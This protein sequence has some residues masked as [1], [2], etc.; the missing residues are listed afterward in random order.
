MTD[1]QLMNAGAS[2]ARR[3]KTLNDNPWKINCRQF[4]MWQ[5]GWLRGKREHLV[6]QSSRTEVPN[7]VKETPTPSNNRN[8][9]RVRV[10]SVPVRFCLARKK[11]S[12]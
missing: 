5:E 10:L 4:D 8:E 6:E 3:G 12:S 1:E 7:P 9:K 2:C 11:S